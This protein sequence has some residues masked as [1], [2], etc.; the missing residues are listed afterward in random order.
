[1][2]LNLNVNMTSLTIWLEKK[3]KRNT[4][5]L[6]VFLPSKNYL[7]RFVIQ[8]I[9]FNICW[10]KSKK[11]RQNLSKSPCDSNLV[12][13]HLETMQSSS[14]W[15][16]WDNYQRGQWVSHDIININSITWSHPL[17]DTVYIYIYIYIQT[18][19]RSSKTRKEKLQTLP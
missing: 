11:T 17:L 5:S 7:S 15:L 18:Q 9:Q 3:K 6:L 12:D 8:N 2:N 13:L 10:M 16:F 14:I 19:I 1:M 4:Y